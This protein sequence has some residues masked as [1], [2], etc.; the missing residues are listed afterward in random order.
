MIRR[1]RYSPTEG[2]TALWKG[3]LLSTC[4]NWLFTSLQPQIHS[5]LSAIIPLPSTGLGDLPLA[6]HPDPAL[7]L[8][9]QVASHLATLL[10]LSPLELIR[11]RLIL[12][13]LGSISSY[14]LAKRTIKEEGG[15]TGLY[16]H[17]NLLLP[18][19]IE[20]TLR[21]L[22]TLSI[23]LLIE[24]KLQISPDVAPLTYATCDLAFG[25]ATSLVMLPIETV[26]R[27]LQVQNRGRKKRSERTV[28]RVRD[29]DYV[30]VVDALWRIATEETAVPRKR[31]LT[32]K[33]E[34]GAF[35]GLKQLYRGVSMIV[36]NADSSSASPFQHMLLFSRLAWSAPASGAGVSM[37]DGRRSNATVYCT[38]VWGYIGSESN[39]SNI[40]FDC[41]IGCRNPTG[42]L[43]STIELH[44]SADA[45]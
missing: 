41:R 11:T 3:Q 33:D 15:L 34:G 22:I 39:H 9:L 24:R 30:G 18:T 12:A 26:R 28:V 14:T 27:R 32:D 45:H 35:Q 16:L 7:P 29:A 43:G 38:I 17:P 10:L 8:A 20:H 4:H 31:G 1:V 19:I 40:G 23:P 44:P 42:G 25:I 36:C 5:T 21:P 37:G 6:S 2:F 13:P